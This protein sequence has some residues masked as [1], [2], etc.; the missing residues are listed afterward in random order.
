MTGSPHDR[1]IALAAVLLA[2]SACGPPGQGPNPDPSVPPLAR[3]APADTVLGDESHGRRM[4]DTEE[5]LLGRIPGVEVVRLEGGGISV[6]IRGAYS[7]T[8]STEP[9]YVVDGMP[10]HPGPG[11]TLTWLS[12][13]DVQRI[14][15]LKD[16]A[17]T[18]FY[19]VRGANG[20]ILI[21]TKH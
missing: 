8:L 11:G 12:P 13:R 6:R 19:G 3:A 15:V 9:L 7:A 16:P 20:V 17:Q 10:V 18:A 2:A 1:A 5:M 4:V 14:E 21:T